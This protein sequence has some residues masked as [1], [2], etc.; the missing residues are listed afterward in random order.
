[1]EKANISLSTANNT[2]RL[3]LT[4]DAG[5]MWRKT[6]LTGFIV[7]DAVVGCIFNV[8]MTKKLPKTL[9]TTNHN[10]FAKIA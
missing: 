8:W 2:Q 9:L 1:M 10:I 3:F 4:A 7:T 5:P 6:K